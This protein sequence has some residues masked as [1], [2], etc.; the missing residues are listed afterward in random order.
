LPV[1]RIG[2]FTPAVSARVAQGTA[3]K[4]QPMN[5]RPFLS[6]TTLCALALAGCKTPY[7]ESDKKREDAKKDMSGDHS[8]QAF[9]GRLRI[10]VRTK[11]FQ[12]LA[13]LMSPN[14]GY[15]W[16][17]A[18]EGETVFSYWQANNVWPDLEA[19][20]QEQFVPYGDFMVAPPKFAAQPNTYPGYRAGVKQ[21]NGSWRFIYFVPAP[22]A[23]EQA[24]GQ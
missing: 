3:L 16:D 7:K 8:F 13:Q 14:F 19:V 12:V 10:A 9:V 22:P 6:L 18:P 17:N 11:D 4:Q 15:R 1:V 5:F 24:L 23:G 21:V 20:L 2:F